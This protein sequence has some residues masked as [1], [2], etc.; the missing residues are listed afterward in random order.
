MVKSDYF[1]VPYLKILLTILPILFLI[2][3]P[4]FGVEEKLSLIFHAEFK[5]QPLWAIIN[6]DSDRAKEVLVSYDGYLYIYDWDGKKFKKKWKS[7]R[8]TYTKFALGSEHTFAF[9]SRVRPIYYKYGKEIKRALLLIVHKGKGLKDIYELSYKKGNYML[10][11]KSSLPFSGLLAAGRCDNQYSLVVGRGRYTKGR[12]NKSAVYTWDG[13]KMIKKW[14]IREDSL[15]SAIVGLINSD[16]KEK[17]KVF[18]LWGNK[19]S[20]LWCDAR[21]SKFR[22]IRNITAQWRRIYPDQGRIGKTRP[23]SS[24]EFWIIQ[25]PDRRHDTYFKLIMAEYDGTEFKPFKQ[26]K[27]NKINTDMVSAIDLVDI[28]GDGMVE[29][30]GSEA[31]ISVVVKGK[32]SK[33]KQIIE[34]RS[35]LFVSEWDGGA[36]N[37]KWKRRASN[38]VITRLKAADITGDGAFE[39]LSIGYSKETRKFSLNIFSS[40]KK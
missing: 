7:R 34:E 22:P 1:Y 4:V 38:D 17:Q 6:T 5:H 28:D 39:F 9:I 11:K 30:V 35:S 3:R 31:T 29:L 33:V 37:V 36:Y 10:Q 13:N 27:I 19:N 25:Q 23:G 18:F 32:R 40:S 24:G 2:S 12:K 14:D 8:F 26:V 21:K 16:H 20:L 15:R